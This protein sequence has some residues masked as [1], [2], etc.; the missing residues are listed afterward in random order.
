MSKDWIKRKE[1]EL[2]TQAED[3]S[4]A[5][6][7]DPTDFALLPADATALASDVTNWVNKYNLAKDPATRTPLTVEDKNVAKAAVI[8]RMRS[9]GARVRSNSAVSNALKMSIGLHIAD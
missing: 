3:M 1:A 4:A 7:A 6:S 2:V 5:I 8:A 9:L